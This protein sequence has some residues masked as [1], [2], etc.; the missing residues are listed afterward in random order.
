MLRKARRM[1]SLPPRPAKGRITLAALCGFVMFSTTFA[2]A[3]AIGSGPAPGPRGASDPIA[4]AAEHDTRSVL[5]ERM[6]LHLKRL[7]ALAGAMDGAT[8]R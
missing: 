2:L 1:S 3:T 6:H 7:H 8:L 4:L 5:D